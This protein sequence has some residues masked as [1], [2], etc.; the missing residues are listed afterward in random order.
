MSH[1]IRVKANHEKIALE[2]NHPDHPDYSGGDPKDIPFVEGADEALTWSS[3]PERERSL[4]AQQILKQQQREQN[5]RGAFHE[6]DAQAHQQG[7]R[8]H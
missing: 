1:K 3:A 6:G 4:K 2:Q 7:N 8:Q 5:E